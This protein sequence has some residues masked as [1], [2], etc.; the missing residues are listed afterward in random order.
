MAEAPQYEQSLMPETEARGANFQSMT[1][2]AADLSAITKG[3]DKVGQAF[4]LAL[5]EANEARAI[6][7]ETRLKRYAIDREKKY[8]TRLG[9]NALTADNQGRSLIERETDDLTQY[10]NKLAKDAKLTPE[11]MRLFAPKANSIITAQY[12]DVSQHVFTQGEAFKTSALI[13]RRDLA[14]DEAIRSAGDPVAFDAYLSDIRKASRAIANRQGVDAT[15][16]KLYADQQI[17]TAVNGA[18][19]QAVIDSYT[20]NS[21]IQVAKDTLDGYREFLSPEQILKLDKVVNDRFVEIDTVKT[22]KD[23]VARHSPLGGQLALNSFMSAAKSMTDEQRNAFAGSLNRNGAFEAGTGSLQFVQDEKTGKLKPRVSDYGIGIGEI[24]EQKIKELGIED[25]KGTLERA[26]KNAEYNEALADAYLSSML[27]RFADPGQALAAGR[28]GSDK[29]A[30][31]IEEHGPDWL[32]AMPEDI[33]KYV[34]KALDLYQDGLEIGNTGRKGSSLTVDY[35]QAST[36]PMTREQI[37]KT[38]LAEKPELGKAPDLLEKYVDATYAE[39]QRVLSDDLVRRTSIASDLQD[40]Y[41]RTGQVNAKLL[42]QLTLAEQIAFNDWKT[43]WDINDKSGDA[44][45]AAQVLSDPASYF[46][47]LYSQLGGDSSAIQKAVRGIILNAPRDKQNEIRD[48]YLNYDAA[49]KDANVAAQQRKAA[50]E[51]GVI[52]RAWCQAN[53]SQIEQWLTDRFGDDFKKAKPDQK[54]QAVYAASTYLAY[55]GQVTGKPIK[56]GSWEFEDLMTSMMQG[57][58]VHRIIF[59]DQK[60]TIFEI[61]VDSDLGGGG[62][63]SPRERL[64]V[65]TARRM[66]PELRGLRSPSA[67]EMKNTLIS[68]MINPAA[69]D[70]SGLFDKDNFAEIR[71]LCEAEMLNRYTRGHNGSTKGYREPSPQQ[72]VAYYFELA[73]AG[74]LPERQVSSAVKDIANTLYDDINIDRDVH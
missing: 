65:L 34:T 24:N 37:T 46:N 6:D 35:F 23:F 43:K 30:K 10:A 20:D 18:I 72:V 67:G 22:S 3:L 17:A 4:N 16:A 32:S 11:Q 26:S 14:I 50:A 74:K 12:G 36:N 54:K 25:V 2:P 27:K 63:N 44:A 8:K 52:D 58:D 9:C 62:P 49:Y 70:V 19:S 21:R 7:L 64:R 40:E 73:L 48:A 29:V 28:V 41:A 38:L 42:S 69:M 13:G 45:L 15:S 66:S 68:L 56:G 51:S 71:K 33:Q 47:R 61:A 1:A 31:A 53:A 59:P 55:Q 5:D 39:Q 57:F 60:K